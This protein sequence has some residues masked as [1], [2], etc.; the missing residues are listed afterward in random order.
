[1]KFKIEIT[2]RYFTLSSGT[3][4]ESVATLPDENFSWD[5]IILNKFK[6]G[7]LSKSIKG[8]KV[9][10]QN[11][12]QIKAQLYTHCANNTI[13]IKSQNETIF[14]GEFNVKDCD[15]DNDDCHLTINT[16]NETKIS[17]PEK[18]KDYNHY[19]D[20]RDLG[21]ITQSRLRGEHQLLICEEGGCGEFCLDCYND[22]QPLPIDPLNNPLECGEFEEYFLQKNEYYEYD[23]NCCVSEYDANEQGGGCYEWEDIVR[24]NQRTTYGRVVT[25]TGINTPPDTIHN[26]VFV[27]VL[28]NGRYL[29]KHEPSST[30][31]FPSTIPNGVPL[32]AL[33]ESML[34]CPVYSHFFSQYND[35]N[36]LP[37]NTPTPTGNLIMYGDLKLNYQNII[38]HQIGDV[39]DTEADEFSSLFRMSPKQLLKDLKTMFN[40]DIRIKEN[41]TGKYYQLEHSNYWKSL[42]NG[43]FSI[44]KFINEPKA[45][46]DKNIKSERWEFPV[47]CSDEW[48]GNEL[49]DY[50]CGHDEITNKITYLS[51][52]V[53]WIA[54]HTDTIKEDSGYVLI[55]C[56]PPDL[57]GQ[58]FVIKENFVLSLSFL[59]T[60]LH[61][62]NRPSGIIKLPNG[63]YEEVDT[64]ALQSFEAE[65]SICCE[66]IDSS[67]SLEHEGEFYNIETAEWNIETDL[68]KLK[69]TK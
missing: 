55:A 52:D 67:N 54:S 40:V 41:E 66:I 8:L 42:N 56:T 69:L 16:I 20:L 1:M 5:C 24:W 57:N 3:T 36:T 33:L 48:K 31:K 58:S 64:M 21:L 63:T 15:F 50:I 10:G 43:C 45:L 13:E 9:W 11:Y 25:T 34:G 51:T 53:A 6:N 37:T 61:K 47:E 46:T 60:N 68:V 29:W 2:Y 32:F 30:E 39:L 27:K 23:K 59:L 7:I 65:A 19:N 14:H 44:D 49:F 12:E 28:T 4:T 35:L 22:Y 62:W 38:I 18:A 26:W 17:C